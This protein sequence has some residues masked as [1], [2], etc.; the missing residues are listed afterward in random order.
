[1]FIQ[2]N[3][4]SDGSL[5]P[6]PAKHVD[7]GMGLERLVSVLQ[8]KRSNYDTDVFAPIF[9]AI[10]RLTNAPHSYTGKLAAQDSGNVDTAYRVIADHIRTLTFAI[11]D[12]A[13][14][15]NVGRGYV[16]RRILRRAV[17]YGRQML[18]ARGG[19][20]SQLVPVVVER[21][22]EAF[23]ELRK[24]PARVQKVIAE[25]EESFG[26]TLDRGIKLFA[27]GGH[28]AGRLSCRQG[29]QEGC[30]REVVGHSLKATGVLQRPE[31]ASTSSHSIKSTGLATTVWTSHDHRR[32]RVQAV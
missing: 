23:P 15:S 3:R 22:G 17:R 12:G 27:A 6:L 20:F 29:S 25:E 30:G 26:K 7:T 19:F 24:D 8:N 5:K 32:R 21:F 28:R 2:F 1:M 11:T 18:G 9:A 10:E 13:V 31:Q 14:P 4:E 16:L